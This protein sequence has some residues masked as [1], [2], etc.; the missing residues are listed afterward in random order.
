MSGAWL[1]GATA[2]VVLALCSGQALAQQTQV[3][4]Q[5]SAGASFWS[6][7]WT[8]DTL[9]GDMGGLRT[10]L[11]QA[12][13]TFNL[14]EQSEVLGNVSGGIRRG[15]D[16][17]GL[18]TMSV[19]VDTDKALHWPGGT[20]FASALQIHGRNLS[21]DYLGNLQTVSGIEAQRTTRLWELWYMQTFLQNKAD[22][23]VGQQSL[24]QEFIVSQYAEPYLNTM[25]GWPMVP[26]ADLYAGGPAYPLSSL[27]VRARAHLNS[28][29]TVLGGVFDDNPPG[30]PFN[31]DSQLRDGEAT[32]TQFNL[33][34]GALWIA[35]LQYAANPTPAKGCDSMFCGLPGTYKLGAWY[36]TAGFPNQRFDIA[37][38]SL[39]SPL[40]SGIAQNDRGNFSVY[41]VADQMVW[42][43][44]DGPR[45]VGVFLRLM[46]APDDR[47]LID[48]SLNAGINVKAP[49]P[50][51][52]NDT[53]GIGYDFAHVSKS[54]S[55]LDGDRAFYSGAAY[56]VRSAEHVIELTYQ[57]QAAPWWVLQPDFQY[58]INPGAGI[59][60]PANKTQRIGDEAVF[61][62]RTTL[63]F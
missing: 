61:G 4:P 57:Y 21:A 3:Q 58:V 56:P 60:N 52:P 12:G 45:S 51:R 40:S 31:D 22:I 2:A 1:S 18:T 23:K 35:E 9:L 48:F 10:K 24:D 50:G 55:D 6:D 25:T 34:T 7:L 41:G 46:G 14:Q 43:E 47:N 11:A 54:A 44:R 17:D 42:R 49:F 33:N 30:G 62:L 26:S 27:G 29:L 8:R 63:T 39:A 37:G 13:I 53:F 59:L 19:S 16:Y 32:G 20:F 38:I 36:D 28:S 5:G 15:A